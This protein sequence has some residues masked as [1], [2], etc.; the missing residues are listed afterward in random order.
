MS[1]PRG[2]NLVLFALSL[3]VLTLMVLMTLSFGARVKSRM[4]LQTIADTAA[5]SNAVATARTLNSIAVLNRVTVAHTVS[6][7]GTLSLIS[8]STLYW[9][10]ARNARDLWFK[11]AIIFAIGLIWCICPG[12]TCRPPACAACKRGI[13]ETGVAGALMGYYSDQIKDKLRRDTVLFANETRP[14]YLAS[15][16]MFAQQSRMHA[17]LLTRLNAPAASFATRFGTQANLRGVTGNAAP[18]ALNTADLDTA[19]KPVQINDRDKTYPIAQIVN[20]SRGHPFMPARNSK[21]VGGIFGP[22]AIKLSFPWS[23]IAA[24]WVFTDGSG[25]GL[26]YLHNTWVGDLPGPPMGHHYGS[27]ANDWGDKTRV[28]LIKPYGP[29]CD[30]FGPLATVV[31]L[32]G[33]GTGSSDVQVGPSNTRGSTTASSTRTSPS[34]RSTTTT[35][36]AWAARTTCTPF[37]RT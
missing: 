11:E 10:H 29:M 35:A 33:K 5:Y 1:S 31:G 2:Q 19:I 17:D 20:A 30:I 37:R 22:W 6:T 4:E 32:L 3:L 15:V 9:K 26:G 27:W 13:V 28:L 36:R 16:A 18:A 21:K 34:R 24:G 14:R 7:I 25:K 12:P 23:I 8:W